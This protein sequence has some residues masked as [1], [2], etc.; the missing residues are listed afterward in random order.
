MSEKRALDESSLSIPVRLPVGVCVKVA[1]LRPRYD[2]LKVWCATA[3]NV[4]VTRN[5]RVFV[6]QSNGEKVV[7]AYP[8][9]RWANPFKLS[10]Y[11]LDQCLLKFEEHLDTMLKDHA[12]REEF[13]KLREVK[14]I[15]C[16]CG[17][18]D[19][20]HRDVILR[21]LRGLVEELQPPKKKSKDD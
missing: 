15:G 16:F 17:P 14:E 4:L 11:S 9:S 3:G 10:E 20:C 5:G 18:K 13:L 1:S 7:F 6:N 19:R 21:K 12:T 8:S 2:N